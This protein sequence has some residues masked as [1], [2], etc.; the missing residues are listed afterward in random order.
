MSTPEL[1]RRPSSVDATPPGAGG[2]SRDERRVGGSDVLV[3]QLAITAVTL[4]LFAFFAVSADNFLT[5]D[6]LLEIA[7]QV[8]FIAIVAVGMTY[9]FIAG[10]LDLSVGSHYGF[11]SIVM[12]W[13]VAEQSLDPWLACA[14]IIGLGAAIG[15]LNGAVTTIIG[16]PSFIVTLGMLSVL[17][18]GSLVISGGFPI[19]WPRD[20][21]S[22]FFAAA[23]GSVGQVPAQVI[24]MAAALVVGGIVL[25]ATVFGYH[26][27]ATG[28]SQE[29]TRKTGINTRRVKILCFVL[30]GALCGLVGALQGGW[31]RTASPSTGTGFELVVIGAVII[32]GTAL[33][34]GEGSIYGTFLGAAILGVLTNGLVLLGVDGNLAIT[35]TGLIIIVAAMLDVT[36]RRSG[37][38]LHLPGLRRPARAARPGAG[39]EG[40]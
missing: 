12:A 23:N 16:V 4:A 9:L 2:P 15:L 27:Y 29:A 28:G 36:L 32:G 30:T 1:V 31:L 10:E 34:G 22:S 20:L 6:N 40:G 35:A 25:R 26:V 39:A 8:S 37:S 38:S 18:G 5:L 21:E 7:R 14:V 19:S 33:F 3:R 11:A 13:L 17:K 24:W